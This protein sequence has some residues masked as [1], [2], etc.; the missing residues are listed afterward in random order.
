MIIDEAI[1]GYS[2]TIVVRN[3]T[4]LTTGYVASATLL[5]IGN[6][7]QVTLI[8]DFTIGS[9]SGVRIKMEL[10]SDGTTW[11]M[12]TRTEQ[13]GDDLLH[14]ERTDLLDETGVKA[15]SFPVAYPYARISAIALNDASNASLG[16]D[17]MLSFV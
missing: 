3:K 10:S 12:P 14:K 13:S 2:E 8:T 16:I 6:I 1:V 17:A 4:S 11:I 15:L 9:S 5:E 7:N